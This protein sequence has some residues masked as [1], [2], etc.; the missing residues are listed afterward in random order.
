MKFLVDLQMCCNNVVLDC[1][2]IQLW[3]KRVITFL[4]NHY[5]GIGIPYNQ[6]TLY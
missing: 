3:I 2:A 5:E 6:C 4:S 1:Y